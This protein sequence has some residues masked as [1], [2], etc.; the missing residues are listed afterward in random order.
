MCQDIQKVT[1]FCGHRVSFWWGKSRFCLFTGEGVDRFHTTY[2]SFK[3][4][5]NKCPRCTVGDE[6]KKQGKVMKRDAFLEAVANKYGKTQ[7]AREEKQ[8]KKWETL[9]EES[10]ANLTEAKKDDLRLQVKEQI[11]F[12]L[13][14]DNMKPSGK[15]AMLRTI[16]G[17]P[18]YH[19]HQELVRFFASRYFKATD[20]NRAL[21]DEERKKLFSITRRARLDRTL[22]AGLNLSQP[23]PLPIREKKAEKGEPASH[24]QAVQTQVEEGIAKVSITPA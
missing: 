24:A 16:L 19:N 17:L 15:I 22:K 14:K 12:Y 8:A 7:D 5:E 18:D 4:D 11:A 2:T 20:K 23:I 21:E 1:F 10:K 13:G 6:I 9:D 3:N